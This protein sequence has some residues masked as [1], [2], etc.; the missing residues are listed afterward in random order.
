MRIGELA[1]RTGVSERALR[2]YEQQGLLRPARRS[3][4][5]REYQQADVRTVGSIRTLLGAGLNTTTIAEVLPCLVTEGTQ[6]VPACPELNPVL[7]HDRDRL[8]AAIADLVAARDALDRIIANAGGSDR[9][10][11]VCPTTS[12]ATGATAGASARAVAG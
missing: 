5:Y 6:L 10:A 12:V 8:S 7:Q 1:D 3:S 2:Y 11:E 9:Q 4:G